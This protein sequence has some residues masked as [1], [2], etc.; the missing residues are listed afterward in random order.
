VGV[1]AVVLIVCFAGGI[2]W[3][4][5]QG[6]VEPIAKVTLQYRVAR[7]AFAPS[8]FVAVIDGGI[9]PVLEVTWDLPKSDEKDKREAQEKQK[10]QFDELIR[11][12]E[13]N[14]INGVEF[15]CRCQWIPER[16][17]LRI[18]SVPELTASGKKRIR[19]SGW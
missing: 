9:S 19:D 12:L 5:V 4:Q 16:A 10:A 1:L 18:V 11:H 15:E 6:K 7:D 2:A 3:A 14:H 17:A 8:Q 13:A